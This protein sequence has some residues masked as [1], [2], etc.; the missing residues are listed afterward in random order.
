MVFFSL[1]YSLGVENKKW[2]SH[3]SCSG[4]LF[5]AFNISLTVQRNTLGKEHL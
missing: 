4:A 3:T 5:S 2:M 1:G